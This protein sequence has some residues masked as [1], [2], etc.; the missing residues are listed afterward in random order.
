MDRAR[1]VSPFLYPWALE[2]LHPLAI[3]NN[4]AMNP[5]VQISLHNPAFSSFGR[6]H[7][8]GISRSHGNSMFNF[9][10]NHHPAPQWQHHFA[11]P[12]TVHVHSNFPP[13]NADTFYPFLLDSLWL[14][15]TQVFKH[16][17]WHL[18]SLFQTDKVE[19]ASV[20]SCRYSPD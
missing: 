2:L 19:K 17:I 16:P 10:R 1:F 9:L 20:D 6:I 8:C 18:P 13:P 12:Q 14:T 7:R 15:K 5:G 4:A 11:F 3:V